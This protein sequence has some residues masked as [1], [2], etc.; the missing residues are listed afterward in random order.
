MSGRPARVSAAR[1]PR[2][3]CPGRIGTPVLP[4]GTR[5]DV[6]AAIAASSFLFVSLSDVRE[7]RVELAQ[8]LATALQTAP[9]LQPVALPRD[10]VQRWERESNSQLTTVRQ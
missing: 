10:V 5:L 1:T 4:V 2:M 3:A 8:R 7:A 9:P 6:L